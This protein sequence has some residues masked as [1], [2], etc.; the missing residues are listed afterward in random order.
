MSSIIP[1]FIKNQ[2]VA[3]LKKSGKVLGIFGP[4]RTGKTFLLKAIKEELTDG[5]ILFVQGDNLDVA[6][7]LSS[8]R[9]TTLENFVKG[10]TYLFIDEAQEIP[11]IGD[12]LK[13][14]ADHCSHLHMIISGSSALDLWQK[15]GEP[16]TGRMKYFHLYPV[17]QA[18]ITLDFLEVKQ[19]LEQ[20]L[21]YGGYPEVIT[22]ENDSERAEILMNLRDSYLLRDI[23]KLENNKDRLFII[24][25]LRLI[26]FQIG[27]DIS[28]A[29]LSS[30]LNV[31]SKTV[32]RYLDL[33][34]KSYVLFSLQGFSRNMR[35]EYTR[36]PRYY[37]WDNGIRNAV[38][39][40]F[41]ALG[42]RDDVGKLFENYSIEER[43]KMSQ[44][45]RII[46]N[47]HFWRTYDQQEIDYIEEREGNLF[48]Y[49]FKWKSNKSKVPSSFAS[50]YP[51]SIFQIVTQDNLF[52]FIGL[53]L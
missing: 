51:K 38:I 19:Q 1:R 8:R 4:R 33:L 36:T 37:F 18:E 15:T 2:V 24:K 22:A 52:D 21:I 43:L 5:K 16:L 7:I 42:S 30:Q 44:Y 39:A 25:L 28:Y 32:I 47:P 48:A 13:L 3:D 34:E 29:E 10:Y 12:N 9:L 46:M 53:S 11:Q 41:N 31:N 50:S 27:N 20:R 17:A 6:E 14:L 49:E 26:A 45:Q 23:L 35:K 40:N